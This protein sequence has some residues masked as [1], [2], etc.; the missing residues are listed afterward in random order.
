MK[1]RKHIIELKSKIMLPANG[2]VNARFQSREAFI[3]L[4]FAI[5]A[6]LLSHQRH[7]C[8]SRR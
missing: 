2:T 7:G 5:R 1:W 8:T 6:L 3:T 4:S